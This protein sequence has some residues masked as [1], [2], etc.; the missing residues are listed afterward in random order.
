MDIKGEMGELRFKIEIKRK[1]T[2]K[3]EEY[4]LIGKIT[5]GEENG[6]NSLDS[7]TERSN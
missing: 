1:D 6:S 3:V 7:S 2:G 4:E 5:E